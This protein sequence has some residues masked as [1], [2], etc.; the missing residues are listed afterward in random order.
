MSP[1]I[2]WMDSFDID[3]HS[4]FTFPL[5]IHMHLVTT[6]M[7]KAFSL[8]RSLCVCVR[9]EQVILCCEILAMRLENTA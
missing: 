1:L 3:I 8:K 7:T 9:Y 4:F 5:D 2:E 6:N